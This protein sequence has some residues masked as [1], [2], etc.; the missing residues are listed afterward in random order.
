MPGNRNDR[1]IHQAFRI[2][3]NELSAGKTVIP[4]GPFPFRHWGHCV[5]GARLKSYPGIPLFSPLK[6]KPAMRGHGIRIANDLSFRRTV[7]PGGEAGALPGR[8]HVP[9]IMPGYFPCLPE[10]NAA[11][12]REMEA[13]PE[14]AAFLPARDGYKQ[15]NEIKQ[16]KFYIKKSQFQLLPGHNFSESQFLKMPF[17]GMLLHPKMRKRGV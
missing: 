6:E 8:G 2:E 15:S 9:A 14:R 16:E 17:S 10:R 7:P 4:S 11:R 13:P 12:P 3:G 5:L 1:G